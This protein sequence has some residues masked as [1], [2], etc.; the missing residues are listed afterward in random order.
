VRIITRK[1]ISHLTGY[2]KEN[3]LRYSVMH[4]EGADGPEHILF[5]VLRR[6]SFPQ[7]EQKITEFIP[8]AFYTVEGVKSAN[9]AG[10]V[11]EQPSRRGIGSWL[12]SVKRK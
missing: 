10:I 8:T 2:L 5:T 11:T 3:K 12:G 6:D 9:E 7:L 1:E 4:S